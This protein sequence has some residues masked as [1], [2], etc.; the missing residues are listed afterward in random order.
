MKYSR[1]YSKINF[2]KLFLDFTVMAWFRRRRKKKCDTFVILERKV[3]S[4]QFC[5]K[6]DCFWTFFEETKEIEPCPLC[7]EVDDV[8]CDFGEVK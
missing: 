3:F 1:R 7:G 6:H 5:T 2:I 4:Q 8:V